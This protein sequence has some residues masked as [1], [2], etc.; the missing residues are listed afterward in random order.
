MAYTDWRKGAADPSL[1]G[2]TASNIAYLTPDPYNAIVRFYDSRAIAP[3]GVNWSH[4]K[5]PEVDKYIDAA[6]NSFDPE[7]QDK[8]IA[9]AHELVVNDA[10]QVWVVHDVNPHALS[11]K[12]KN[13]VQAQHW[14]QD[15]TTLG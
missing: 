1:A 4:Y 12:V 14:F 9:K 6:N 5:N 2:I 3:R 15:L 11:P 8:L 13:Y 7:E 10:V